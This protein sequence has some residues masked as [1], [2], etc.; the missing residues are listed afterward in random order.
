MD[1]LW[2]Q[3]KAITPQADSI[4]N[5][6]IKNGEPEVINDHIAFRTI[7]SKKIGIN[8]ISSY[9]E[10]L[11]YEKKEDYIFEEKKL[12]AIHLEHPDDKNPKIFIS[13]ILPEKLSSFSQ[14]ICKELILRSPHDS[15]IFSGSPWDKT[16]KTYKKLYEESEYLA[17]FYLHGFIANHF[18]VS[19]NHL[20]TI[21]SIE[22]VNELIKK[23][24]FP[25]NTSG[26]EI[27]GSKEELLKQ[28]STLASKMIMTFN[29]G[30]FEVPTCF[31]E[32]AQ[33]FPRKDGALFQG[34][35]AKSADKIFESTN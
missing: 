23:E 7:K 13:E 34:F 29:D 21:S 1:L 19:V 28:S 27:K 16:Y 2:E 22:E 6:L 33:R 17:W 8:T 31:Y 5:L 9:F 24:N 18:T 14:K 35:I 4:Q 26:G 32:F 12:V 15:L 3:Y 11:G 25:L 20:K 10:A 30:E